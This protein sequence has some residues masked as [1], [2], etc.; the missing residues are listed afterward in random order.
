MD[1]YEIDEKNNASRNNPTGANKYFLF[2]FDLRL[3]S[4]SKSLDQ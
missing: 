4:K 3:F 1:N 2:S